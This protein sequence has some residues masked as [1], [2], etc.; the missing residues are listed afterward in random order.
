MVKSCGSTRGTSHPRCRR[1]IGWKVKSW[2]GRNSGW[3]GALTCA[4]PQFGP[5]GKRSKATAT[6]CRATGF[7]TAWT[8]PTSPRCM[9]PITAFASHGLLPKPRMHVRFLRER[10]TSALSPSSQC[11]AHYCG[12]GPLTGSE[13]AGAICPGSS[14]QDLC[15]M[16][17]LMYDGL[18]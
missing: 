13:E 10:A 7:P 18:L 9:S 6:A 8:A 16:C 11:Q 15:R 12:C 5:S 2:S 3:R 4:L 17:G 1:T 14:S